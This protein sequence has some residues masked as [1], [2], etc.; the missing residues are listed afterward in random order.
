MYKAPLYEAVREYGESENIR[1]HMPGHGGKCDIGV[2]SAVSRYDITELDGGINILDFE[3][4][5]ARLARRLCA[6]AFGAHASVFSCSGATLGLQTALLAAKKL[7]KDNRCLCD[8]R[9]HRSVINALTLLGIE[10]VWFLPD[11]LPKTPSCRMMIFTSCDY[12]GNVADLEKISEFC[13]K[14]SIFSIA[15]NSHG[16]HLK[17]YSDGRLHPLTHGIDLIVDSAHKTLPVLTGGAYLHASKNMSRYFSKDEAERFLLECM[18]LF[19]TTSPNFLIAAS[20]DL[21][22]AKLEAGGSVIINKMTERLKKLTDDFPFA[23]GGQRDPLRLVICGGE[24]LARHLKDRGIICEFCDGERVILIPRFDICDTETDLLYRALKEFD[25]L[26]EYN[27][28]KYFL[29]KARRVYTP[30]DTLCINCE[31]IP[32]REALGKVSAAEYSPYPP[33]IPLIVPGEIFDKNT[34]N[35]LEGCFEQVEILKI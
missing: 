2:L 30:S 12:Y 10:P 8:R 1:F 15:D 34:I 14:H 3:N 16:T 24:R 22:R 29:P 19:S 5:T 27:A 17:F 26:C 13:K 25:G 11:S 33:G 21:A 6:N 9:C 4:G 32:L 7:T 23:K 28:P 31:K 20:L 35:L 18:A